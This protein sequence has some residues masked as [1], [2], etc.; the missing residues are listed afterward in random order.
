MPKERGGFKIFIRKTVKSGSVLEIEEYFSNEKNADCIP[1]KYPAVDPEK[2]RETEYKR[3]VKRLSRI[4]NA[5]FGEG[6]LFVTLS[7]RKSTTIEKAK[8]DLFNYLLR[9]KRY[10]AREGLPPIKYLYVTEVGNGGANK[11]HHLLLNNM[12]IDKV[13]SEWTH[14]KAIAS[15][16]IPYSDYT[17]IAHYITKENKRKYAC[18]YSRS[19]NLIV[20]TEVIE[21]AKPTI[22]NIELPKEY[23]GYHVI[24]NEN[25]C[26]EIGVRKYLKAIAPDGHDYSTGDDLLR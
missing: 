11:H 17:G 18:S 14:G 24:V 26:S 20:P 6:D 19:R 12:S 1:G 8:K 15:R 16:L 21:P 13:T 5:N 25:Y 22:E 7:Y 4:V 9:L 3:K 10:R 23:E 2:A